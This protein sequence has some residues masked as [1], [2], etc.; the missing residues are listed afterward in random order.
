MTCGLVTGEE[1][2]ASVGG[3]L[4]T[5]KASTARS[6]KNNVNAFSPTIK[7]NLILDTHYA[8]CGIYKPN[9][10][11]ACA[12]CPAGGAVNPHP[13]NVFFSQSPAGLHVHHPVK[14]V[15]LDIVCRHTLITINK[16]FKKTK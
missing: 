12:E 4:E 10:K 14:Q 5:G 16:Y 1:S 15:H 9:L 11:C 3:M 13:V 7:T 6:D 2:K 8:I